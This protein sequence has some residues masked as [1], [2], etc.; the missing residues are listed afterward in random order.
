MLQEAKHLLSGLA[1]EA[2][3]V[4][5]MDTPVLQE[6]RKAQKRG[7]RNNCCRGVLGQAVGGV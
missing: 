5:M 3:P 1:S 6:S 7:C 4:L 2:G